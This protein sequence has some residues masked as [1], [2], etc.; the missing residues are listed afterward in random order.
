VDRIGTLTDAIVLARDLAGL[1]PRDRLEVR[2]ESDGAGVL[3][4]LGNV[5]AVGEPEGQL[6]HLVRQIPEAS[7]LLLLADMGPLLAL[8][9]VWLAPARP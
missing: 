2:R 8:P 3:S 6:A 5:L 7:A 4:R 1:D 9:E